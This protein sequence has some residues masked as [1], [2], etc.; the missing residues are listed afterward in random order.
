[1]SDLPGEIPVP[2][3]VFLFWLVVI[4]WRRE[5]AAGSGTSWML[6]VVMRRRRRV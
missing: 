1:M 6:E 3:Q 5:V 4:L 2:M